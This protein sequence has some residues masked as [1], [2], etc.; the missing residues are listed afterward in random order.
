M[1]TKKKGAKKKGSNVPTKR[2]TVSKIPTGRKLILPQAPH[3]MQLFIQKYAALFNLTEM[4]RYCNLPNGTMRHIAKDNR[5]MTWA[6]YEDVRK[7]VLPVML[8]FA[9]ILQ[10]YDRNILQIGVGF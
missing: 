8:E 5:P 1:A 2:N 10:N 6:Q 9:L 3:T 4:E 7:N